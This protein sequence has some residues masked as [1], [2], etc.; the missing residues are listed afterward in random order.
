MRRQRVVIVALSG[1]DGAGKSS[2]A[3]MLSTRLRELG[4]SATVHWMALGH[5]PLQR[6]LRH[7]TARVA[8]RPAQTQDAILS[9]GGSVKRRASHHPIVTHA[10][11]TL[12]ALI[13]AVHFRRVAAACE[14]DVVIF[15]R[16]ALDALAQSRYFYAPQA[17]FR[18]A[19]ALLRRLAPRPDRAYLLAVAPET[20]LGRKQEQYDAV[21][22]GLQAE[23]LADEAARMGVPVLDGS[24]QQADLGA[25]LARDAVALLRLPP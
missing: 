1:L 20:A 6:R 11:V 4:H 18:V 9:A 24:R 19:R 10:W 16:Y 14:D 5:N 23:L 13:Y 8:G 22:L 25:D 21:Q 12:L 15:D 7:L 17:D 2:Q 3:A